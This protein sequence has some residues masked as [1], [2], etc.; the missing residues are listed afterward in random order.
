[1]KTFLSWN[2]I[3]KAALDVAD[4]ITFNNS[5][6]CM[7]TCILAIARGGLVPATMIAHSL[8]IKDIYIA[9]ASSYTDDNTKGN[10]SIEIPDIDKLKGENVLIVDDLSDS[11]D[12]LSAIAAKVKEIAKYV[13]TATLYIKLDTRFVP[14]AYCYSFTKETWLVF[15]WEQDEV[16]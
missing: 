3:T 14:D 2:K 12:T 7:P 4:T 5:S 16:I 15:P 1:M 11:G 9:R 10:L 6:E 8:N 13:T